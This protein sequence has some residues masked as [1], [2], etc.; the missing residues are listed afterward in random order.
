M[1]KL[2]RF[3]NDKDLSVYEIDGVKIVLNGWN[4]DKWTNCF[5]L[6]ENETDIIKEG[7]EVR[8][9]YKELKNGNFELINLI[10]L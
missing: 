10:I 6:A 9:E 2:R 8:P 1:K 7:I 3:W 4:G 5:E